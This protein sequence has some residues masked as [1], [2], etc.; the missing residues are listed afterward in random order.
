MGCDYY[1][2]KELCIY[3]LHTKNISYITLS[4]DNGYFYYPDLDEDHEN[5]EKE[6]DKIIKNQLKP[7]MNPILVYKDNNFINTNL[8]NKY[9]KL[10]EENFIN[11]YTWNEVD[12]IIKVESRYERE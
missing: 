8:E 6:Y 10:I 4:S 2:I 9:K 1:I 11:K 7:S 12:K 5:Y 3:Y